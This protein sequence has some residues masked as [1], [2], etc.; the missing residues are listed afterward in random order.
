VDPVAQV[1]V[2]VP[3]ALLGDAQVGATRVE[4]DRSAARVVLGRALLATATDGHTV[5][6]R[7]AGL[8]RGV[9]RHLDVE[10]AVAIHRQ[11]AQLPDD[12]G[13]VINDGIGQGLVF[14]GLAAAPVGV[15]EDHPRGYGLGDPD[16][17]GNVAL[18]A[19][20]DEVVGPA[21]RRQDPLVEG[22]VDAQVGTLARDLGLGVEV[23]VV[24]GVL[25]LCRRDDDGVREL[26]S[27]LRRLV[28]PQ[29]EANVA[30]QIAG[31]AGRRV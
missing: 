20:P 23:F 3:P 30:A 4:Q 29:G 22:L 7:V 15:L 5:G 11:L 12:L 28:Q 1:P 31:E 9:E 27:D 26:C 17:H 18:V 19:I 10:P 16:R 24:V 2:T 8:Q 21:V 13:A 6:H 25:V 14:T